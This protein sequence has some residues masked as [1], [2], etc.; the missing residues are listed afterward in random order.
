M[1]SNKKF[2]NNE[3]QEIV[4][5]VGD[6]GVF[7]S[8]SSGANIKKDIFFQKYS[9]MVDPSSFFQQQSAAGLQNLTEQ[10][11]SIDSSKV[12]DI[13]GNI[14]PSVKVNQES[15]AEQLQAPPEYRDMLMKKYQYEQEHKDLSQYKVFEN[16]DEAADDWERKIKASQQPAPQ[17]PRPRPPQMEQTQQFAPPVEP[18]MENAQVQQSPVYMS[19]EEEAFRFFKSF[20][21]IHPISVEVSFDEKIAQPDFI[22][23]M[24]VNYEGDIIKYYTKEIMNRI[25]NDPGFLENKIYEKLKSII[26]E[27]SAK[28]EEQKPVEPKPKQP[29]KPRATKKSN[30][31]NG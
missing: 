25:Y 3:T 27:E 14:P 10:L 31:N 16:E 22:R 6:N 18:I 13:G 26:F 24:V 29:R 17:R 21:R 5:I 28:K 15:V 1:L 9:E 7:Y 12:Q 19:A 20:K 30:I 11:R 23:M 8:L 2:Q 4:A